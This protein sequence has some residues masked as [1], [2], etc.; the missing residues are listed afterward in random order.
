MFIRMWETHSMTT[1]MKQYT[2]CFEAAGQGVLDPAFPVSEIRVS[3]SWNTRRASSV[4]QGRSS[5]GQWYPRA[6]NEDWYGISKTRGNTGFEVLSAAICDRA[7]RQKLFTGLSRY[8]I[9]F[10][11]CPVRI[12][13]DRAPRTLSTTN[14]LKDR[15]RSAYMDRNR[16]SI[17][18]L[19]RVY[20]SRTV[21]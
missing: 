14:F 16:S 5:S 19:F 9:Y 21:A 12:W 8:L 17:R 6:S 7:P 11:N 1:D 20:D 4:H 2:Y 18:E 15:F 10:S 3:L 13:S